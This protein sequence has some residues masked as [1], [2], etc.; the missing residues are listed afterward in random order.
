MQFLLTAWNIFQC[1]PNKYSSTQLNIRGF[2]GVFFV[3]FE[4]RS[5]HDLFDW[6]LD[7]KHL[8]PL[9]L[10]VEKTWHEGYI[11]AS[12]SFQKRFS[13]SKWRGIHITRPH[14][15][16]YLCWQ[17]KQKIKTRWPWKLDYSSQPCHKQLIHHIKPNQWNTAISILSLI[18]KQ[19]VKLPSTYMWVSD[20]ELSA[21]QS[22]LLVLRNVNFS[23]HFWRQF[24][25]N[26]FLL[27]AAKF[28][29]AFCLMF[30]SR[31]TARQFQGHTK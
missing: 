23:N 20:K 16:W 15:C 8:S 1:S 21:S 12:A 5:V 19:N 27:I 4:G 7:P 31:E 29:A 10:V 28:Y 24:H 17:L 3:S 11:A 9:C 2:L 6:K 30:H 25:Q 26:L 18:S 22:Y 14:L 13:S